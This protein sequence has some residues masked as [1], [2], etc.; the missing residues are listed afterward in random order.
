MRILEGIL[1]EQSQNFARALDKTSRR[2]QLLSNN[3]A[4]VD[5]PGYKRQ[6]TDFAIELD[7]AQASSFAP[8]SKFFESKHLSSRASN[9]TDGNSVDLETEVVAMNE[10]SIRYQVLTEITSRYFAGLKSVIREGR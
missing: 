10:T 5:T 3:L 7:A 4:N 2:H 8:K 6:D 9:R 1:G